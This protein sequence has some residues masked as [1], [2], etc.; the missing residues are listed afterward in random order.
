MSIPY[1]KNWLSVPDQ[2]Q[3]LQARGLVI[4]D[5]VSAAEFLSHVNYYCFTGY[6]LVFEQTRHT[7]IAGTTFEQI[8]RTYE[9]DRALRDLL[10]ESIELIELDL[11]TTIAHTFGEVYGPFG[12][13]HSANFHNRTDHPD[14][15]DKLQGETKRSREVFIGHYKTKY[16]E[17]PDLPIWVAIEV[18]SFGALSKMY[19]GLKKSDQKRVSSRYGFQPLTLASCIHHLVYV[20][21]LCAHH[22]RVWDR[23]WAI[24]PDLP[25]GNLWMAPHLPDN[26]QLLSSLLIQSALLRCIAAEQTFTQAWRQRVQALIGTQI[27]TCPNPFQKMGLPAAWNTHPLWSTP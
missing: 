7:Y 26:T 13:I 15:L 23:V 17:Y 1:P 21:N 8:R 12:H 24:K 25:A 18:M 4:T 3:K 11:R 9:F 2:L 14:W 20:R 6:G 22:S 19:Q 5:P 27:P 10:T 16:Q